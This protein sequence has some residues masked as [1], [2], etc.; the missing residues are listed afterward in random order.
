[1]CASICVFAILLGV[2]D[3]SSL[4]A[5]PVY[6]LSSSVRSGTGLVLTQRGELEPQP[7]GCAESWRPWSTK[8]LRLLNPEE[9]LINLEF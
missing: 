2:A 1:M 7:G 8:R 6:H 9:Y 5:A 3:F 4:E